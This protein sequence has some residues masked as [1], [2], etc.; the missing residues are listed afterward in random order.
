[1]N[2]E[3]VQWQIVDPETN[4]VF[5]WFTH[6]F[7]DVLKTWD[8]H[9]K[10]VLE[11]GAGRSTAWWATKARFVMSVETNKEWWMKAYNEVLHRGLADK[12]LFMN[13]Q[14]KEGEENPDIRDAYLNVADE[15]NPIIT[16]EHKGPDIVA[17]DGILRY[18]C[19]QKSL[20]LLRERGG[21]I[22]ADNW[23]QDR[24][25]ISEPAELLM[26][27]YPGR[28]YIQPD[29]TDHEGR[30]WCTAYWTIGTPMP[31][32]FKESNDYNSHLPMLWM[33]LEAVKT[34]MVI[35]CGCGLG[36]TPLLRRYCEWQGGVEKDRLFMT[37]ENNKEWVLKVLDYIKQTEGEQPICIGLVENGWSEL[38]IDK[39][40][41][42]FIDCAPGEDR[43]MLV[44]KHRNKAQI[45]IVHD[46]EPGAEH[47]YHI[48]EALKSFK[49]R[50]DLLIPGCPQT[51]AVS[52]TYDFAAWKG[53]FYGKYQFV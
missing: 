28:K 39:A 33:A 17:V 44:E 18:E 50:C 14:A 2:D 30:P 32:E 31:E 5:P 10:T 4:C 45:L 19:L 9:D 35:E 46:T 27:P 34:G 8:L 24:V 23:Q 6:P 53:V 40:A 26:A 52:E 20:E 37:C 16:A 25:W 49:Y 1:M 38:K 3:L 41:I 15:W 51:T 12:V 42:L 36:S 43:A 47:V 22:I 13:V 11:Y 48:Q 7:L 21:I 29:H